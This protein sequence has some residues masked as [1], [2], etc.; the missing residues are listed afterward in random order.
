[1]RTFRVSSIF[2]L[3]VIF[4][5][6][7]LWS[8]PSF[9]GNIDPDNNGFSYVYGENVGWFNAEPSGNSGPGLIVSDSLLTGYFWAENIGW[10]SL[11]CL[12]TGVCSTLSYGVLNDGAGNLSGYAWSENVGWINFA[13]TGGWVY[14]DGDGFF[15]G[16]AWGE[17]IGWV[18]FISEGDVSFKVKT[19]WCPAVDSYPPVTSASGFLSGWLNTDVNGVLSAADNTC[20]TGV[21]EV[22]YILD[23]GSE[24]VIS[25]STATVNITTDG[26]HSLNYLSVDNEGNAE[27]VKALTVRI[28]KTLPVVNLI[29]PSDGGSY[30]INNAI[31][32]SYSASDAT[33]GV[34]SI[35]GTVA[36]DSQI[37]T[38]TAGTKGF[39]V[40]ATDQAGNT[41]SITHNYTVIYPGNID[42]DSN[43]SQYAWGENI[44]WVN[45]KPSFGPGVTV[46][47]TSV[48]GYA[49]NEN[50]GWINLSPNTY[51]GVVN[52]GAGILSG[53]AWSENAGWI[54][55][56]PTNGGVAID[57]ATGVFKG[58]A[59]GENTGWIIFFT[60]GG[61]FSYNVK[62]VVKTSWRGNQPP[63]ADNQTLT[64]PEDTPVT[65]SLTGS[66]PNSNNLTFTVLANPTYGTLLGSAP[67]LAYTPDENFNGSD[68]FTFKVNDGIADSN[69]AT[70]SITITPVNDPP[71]LNVIGA[72][73]VN[74]NTNLNFTVSGSD[75][76][77]DAVTL[78]A[79]GL[80]VGATFNTATGVFD[81]TPDYTQSGTYNVTF[82]ISDSALN[83]SETVPITVNDVPQPKAN[84]NG[85]SSYFSEGGYNAYATFGVKYTAGSVTPSGN[86]TF[87]SSRYRR[88]VVSTGITSLTVTGKTAVFTGPCTVNG[89]NGYNFTA[90]VADNAT[91]G[92]GS[93][94][95]AI[96]VTG[97]NG[98]N[99]SASGTVVSGEYNVSK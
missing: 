60:S 97:P 36:D 20:G 29:S 65:V 71:V 42:P 72:K 40:T 90:I 19:S 12:N 73:G 85:S 48:T 57:P 7:A 45:M 32:A 96:T 62:P 43:G 31:T 92:R 54:N 35:T 18:T 63:V 56:A 66:D 49:W 99:Y 15:R 70:I 89:V 81:W 47:D 39:S 16:R 21:K 82:T 91:P 88:K 8:T 93:D 24:V 10:V 9:A 75:P 87:T 2:I 59:W 22:R 80:P 79:T 51:G 83:T 44:G 50:I 17:N 46:T 86:L 52:N 69:I 53:Y 11:S 76:D 67:N 58:K 55:F 30:Y 14:I 68:S 28:D 41:I 27:A 94:T 26:I 4:L 34:A 95:F 25:G 74:E 5:V 3:L 37:E 38:G 33:S 23:G 64:T 98:F 77:G 61:P 84:S 78:S 1:M 6:A 13:P